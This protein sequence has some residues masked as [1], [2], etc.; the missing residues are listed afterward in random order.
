MVSAIRTAVAIVQTTSERYAF[1][2]AVEGLVHGLGKLVTPQT[3]AKLLAAGLNVDAPPPAIPRESMATYIRVIAVG[4]FPHENEAEAMRLTGLHFI[5]GWQRTL[6]GGAA[7]AVLRLI[8]PTRALPRMNRAF[9][10]SDNF[11]TASTEFLSQT[12]A[13]VTVEDVNTLEHYWH[14][15]FQ[16]ALEM[17]G[18][19]QGT[20]EM[21]SV[22]EPGARYQL[23]W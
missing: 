18:L 23:T 2:A 14:G 22:T 8:G 21:V 3:R 11:S 20:V 7:A 17:M 13:I 19:K 16:G 1:P 10:T 5:R 12:T 4:A 15:I 6:L 9:R